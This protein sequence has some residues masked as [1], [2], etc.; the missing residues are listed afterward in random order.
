MYEI[1]AQFTAW[2]GRP[3]P[4][5]HLPTGQAGSLARNALNNRDI[6]AKCVSLKYV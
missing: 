4:R 5:M 2:S 6:L 3:E 1:T